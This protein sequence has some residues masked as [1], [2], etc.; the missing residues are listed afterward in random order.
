RFVGDPDFARAARRRHDDAAW[1]GALSRRHRSGLPAGW[2]DDREGHAVLGPLWR[3]EIGVRLAAD[4]RQ[5]QAGV[6]ARG[7]SAQHDARRVQGGH[8]ERQ[9]LGRVSRLEHKLFEWLAS[10][11]PPVLFFAQMFGIFGVPIPD[12]L[13]MTISGALVRRGQMPAL[14]TA[15]AALTG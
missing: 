9:A 5:A 2:K 6:A 3:R 12:E 14:M 4:T 13:L 7:R 1:H 15:V 11:G 8:G 10:Y